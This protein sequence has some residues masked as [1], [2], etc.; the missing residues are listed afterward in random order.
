MSEHTK[1]GAG[2][3]IPALTEAT[4]FAAEKHRNQ[5]RKD[6]QE[7]PY[8]NHPIMVVNLLA[9]VGRITN[10]E[11]LQAGM[12]HDTIEDTDTTADEIEGLFGKAVRK[13]VMEVTDDKSLPKYERKR[14]QAEHAPHLSPNAKTIKVADKIANLNDLAA[15]PPAD[16]PLERIEQYVHWANSVVEGCRGQNSALESKYDAKASQLLGA[17]R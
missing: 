2:I 6:A 11:T 14:L 5:R 3:I 16:W 17:L 13:L 12:L 8:I 1:A 7:T 4:M 15:S 9:N 10:I